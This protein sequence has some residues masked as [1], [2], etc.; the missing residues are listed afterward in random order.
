[1]SDILNFLEKSYAFGNF[2]EIQDDTETDREIE[3]KFWASYSPDGDDLP[4]EKQSPKNGC[5]S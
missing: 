4:A 2:D 3:A 5:N 1:M